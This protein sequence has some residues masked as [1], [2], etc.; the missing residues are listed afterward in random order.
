MRARLT[1]VVASIIVRVLPPGEG[2]RDNVFRAF[3]HALKDGARVARRDIENAHQSTRFAPDAPPCFT[4]CVPKFPMLDTEGNE[5]IIQWYNMLNGMRQQHR[6][7][8]LSAMNA[9]CD[10]EYRARYESLAL[11]ALA[12]PKSGMVRR[13]L[14]EESV[15]ALEIFVPCL[16]KRL[17]EQVLSDASIKLQAITRGHL[18]RQA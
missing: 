18:L 13:L 6:Q 12:S 15:V 17:R 5:G 9:K 4:Y 10:A 14:E 8:T 1:N 16:F 11:A 2:G 7:M 3:Y